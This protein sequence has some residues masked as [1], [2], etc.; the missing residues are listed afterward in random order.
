MFLKVCIKMASG[1]T[2]KEDLR[3]LSLKVK[4][5]FVEA[6]F[7]LEQLRVNKIVA[8]LNYD[9]HQKEKQERIKKAKQEQQEIF[10]K[11]RQLKEPR[12]SKFIPGVGGYLEEMQEQARTKGKILNLKDEAKIKREEIK[13]I[14]E[15]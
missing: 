13:N 1:Q 5:E 6:K 15:E 3:F 10:A 9:I 4:K 8:R 12:E 7:E 11:I 2:S 14:K